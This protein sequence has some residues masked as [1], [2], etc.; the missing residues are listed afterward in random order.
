[1]GKKAGRTPGPGGGDGGGEQ[2]RL[3]GNTTNATGSVIG[4]NATGFGPNGS[5]TTA[6]PGVGA[7]TP[8]PHQAF[9]QCVLRQVAGQQPAT[10]ASAS[11]GASAGG[12][13]AKG[14]A[15]AAEGK[16]F[17]TTA[18]AAPGQGQGRGDNGGA[19]ASPAGMCRE[20]YS[21]TPMGGQFGFFR[22]P[23][24]RPM[25]ALSTCGEPNEIKKNTHPKNITH[26]A[27]L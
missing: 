18:A 27:L 19:L 12:K 13:P 22:S 10:S 20:P 21:F 24:V 15:A 4:R 3:P 11:A 2:N 17:N 9:M 1:M 16:L 8:L 6:V 26:T 14:G 5:A 7:G 23:H 25:W